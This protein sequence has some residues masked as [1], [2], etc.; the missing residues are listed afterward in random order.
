MRQIKFKAKIKFPED[1]PR[2]YSLHRIKHHMHN[3]QWIEGDLHTRCAHPHIHSQYDTV[4]PID[5]DTVCEFTG[6]QDKNG[7]DIYDGD[8]YHMGDPN[9]RY[10][11]VWHDTGFIGKQIGS[12]S[13]AGLEH[14]KEK[15][16]V[17]G[18]THNNAER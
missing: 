18:N 1:D 17:V 12:S 11:V 13:Y 6:L 15:I 14:W 10:I 9:I 2:A 4:A 7:T 3:G 8:I 16:E 5:L